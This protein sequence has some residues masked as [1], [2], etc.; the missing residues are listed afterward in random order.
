MTFVH[1]W[2]LILLVVPVAYVA[3]TWRSSSRHL[4]LVLKAL[5]LA[6][7]LVGLSEPVLTVPETKTATVFA[8]DT[9]QSVSSDDLSKASQ[10]L[11]EAER[12]RG[13]NWMRIVP[14]ARQTR[15]LETEETTGRLALRRTSSG[16]DATDIETALDESISAIPPGYI[17]RVVLLSDGNENQGSTARAIAQIAR[18]HIPIDTIP[19]TGQAE[20]SI[21]LTSVAMPR[22]AYSGEQ[23]P[24]DLRLNVPREVHVEV[25]VFAEGKPLGI[26][27]VDLHRG[28]NAVRVHARVD[29]SGATA[30][31]GLVRA[32]G[33]GEAHFDRAV[34]LQRAKVLYLSQDPAG[35]EQNLFSA[36]KEAQFDVSTDASDLDNGLKNTQLVVLNNLDL[37][38]LPTNQ[39]AELDRY[40][41]GG[42][43]LLLI[44]GERQVYKEDKKMD[45]LD[46]ILPAKL[47]PPKTPEGICVALII[48]K[49]SSMEGRKIELARVSAS[50]VVD[51]L[52]PS[53]SIGILIFD[54]SYEWAVPVRKAGDKGDIKRLISGITPDGGTQIAP[55]LAEAYRKISASDA[56][57]KHIVLL[58]D[59]ISEEGDSL[60]LAREA[61]LHQVT[62]STVGLGQDVN[63]SYLEKV[64]EA[65]GGKSYFLNEPQGL[66]QIL[67]K[68]VE[69]FSGK[70]AIEKEL[71]PL[72]RQ[73]AEILD[74]TDMENAPPLKGYA[75][76]AAKP[77]ANTVLA[78]NQEKQDP[79]YTR[80]EYG[81]GRSAVFTSD[82]KSRW[83]E[84][85]MSWK[86]FDK[87]WINV[88]RDLLSHNDQTEASAEFDSGSG[89]LVVNYR[90]AE[91][92]I[93]PVTV[94]K[95]YVIGPKGFRKALPIE[96]VT[97]RVYRGRLHQKPFPGL[98]RILP[99]NEDRMFPEIGVYAENREASDHGANEDLLRE[100]ASSTGGRFNPPPG[101]LL[102]SSGRS[103]YVNWEIWP[104]FLSLGLGL[105]VAELVTRKWGGIT[106]GAKSLLQRQA[107]SRL[108]LRN[109]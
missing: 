86:G 25:Q 100:L 75:R 80:W 64:A 84:Q 56:T 87:F 42:G 70:T 101:E 98:F 65:S 22:E 58:T 89:D 109:D 69:D 79:L 92:T 48:D 76:F 20:R 73:K 35:S 96:R 27:T 105:S 51:H 67:L 57:A 32:S 38:A 52:R 37:E 1:H 49:S 7:I 31:S 74:G 18:L 6:A 24:I 53:D 9:S 72:V 12:N 40:V 62:I 54:N 99:V 108:I 44:G 66:E 28:S 68:D 61:Q 94:P 103:L 71:K 46:R 78:I 88:T 85:W 33:M 21:E 102:M 59:G 3:W 93:G 11:S 90:L 43:G 104:L 82:A 47:A 81:L 95:I 60:E 8:V 63:R 5:S 41:T 19:L 10:I 26:E 17:P 91:K 4:S 23:I 45:A 30:I 14:F 16:G 50:G 83:A 13:R 107:G 36:F 77:G 97:D 39:K 106:Q 15:P 2:P 55:A 34:E 29:S